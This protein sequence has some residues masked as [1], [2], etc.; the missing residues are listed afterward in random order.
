M[1]LQPAVQLRLVT[2]DGPTKI[3]V[4][5]GVDKPETEFN[6]YGG[7]SRRGLRAECAECQAAYFAAGMKKCI[8]C[9]SDRKLSEYDRYGGKKKELRPECKA[10]VARSTAKR[11]ARQEAFEA[12]ASAATRTCS[13]CDMERGGDEFDRYRDRK[14]KVRYR[15]DCRECRKARTRVWTDKN[16]QYVRDREKKWRRKNPDKVKNASLR[17][18]FGIS[19]ADYHAMLAAQGGRCAICRTDNPGPKGFAVD[20][21]H[22]TGKVRG[23]LCVNCNPGLG[24]FK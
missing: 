21:D 6:K 9:G 4:K 10:C 13:H 12:R 16:R 24:C 14:G 19:L 11:V 7:W 22:A 17:N 8:V 20:H 2:S 15:S 3:C 1:A 23:L 18:A 5:C